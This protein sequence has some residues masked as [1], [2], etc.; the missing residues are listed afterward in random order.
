MPYPRETHPGKFRF[1]GAGTYRVAVLEGP[2]S[3]IRLEDVIENFGA[4]WSSE[5]EAMLDYLLETFGSFGPY[6]LEP[7]TYREKDTGVLRR[8]LSAEDFNNLVFQWVSLGTRV[9]DPPP[10]QRVRVTRAQR[11]AAASVAKG[12]ELLG[13]GL[14]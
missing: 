8:A 14:R 13:R 12:A 4:P 10:D 2:V 11:I 9:T 1:A 3:V 6:S 5:W 7:I